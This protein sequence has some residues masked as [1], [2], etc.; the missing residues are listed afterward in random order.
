MQELLSDGLA[1]A[2]AAAVARGDDERAGAAAEPGALRAE[3]DAALLE[4]DEPRVHGVLDRLFARVSL[5]SALEDVVL[6]YL[7][8]LGDRW[9]RGEVSVAQEH[10]ASALLRGRL[11]GLAR[12]WGQGIG[13]RA[14]LVCAPG[15]Q[16]DLGL[17]AFGLA[18]RARGWRILYLGLDTP[19][20]SMASAAQAARPHRIVISAVEAA[21]IE[22]HR[23]EL[24]RLATRYPLAVG[25][26][27]A[28][29]V[30]LGDDVLLLTGGAVEEA[31]RLTRL[32]HDADRD[33]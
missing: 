22:A 20:E 3:L 28:S 26:A 16:H 6:P 19:L 10:F 15:E 21:R 4:L 18:L 13:R 30:M 11:F 23:N 9:A 31:E 33:R 2:E 25:G 17:V 5:D 29:Q 32:V 7:H 8:E 1:A 14:L 12:G 27:A 24:G